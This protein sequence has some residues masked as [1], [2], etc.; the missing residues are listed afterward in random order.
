[1][2]CQVCSKPNH[3]AQDC[4]YRFDPDYVPDETRQAGS[5]ITSYGIDTNWYLDSGATDHITGELDK[6]T[7]RERY[8]SHDKVH[9]ANRAGMVISHIGSTTIH[10][11]KHKLHLKNILHVPEAK[12]SLAS[13]HKIAIDNKAFVEIHLE[14]FVV[15]DR[16]RLFFTVDVMVVSIPSSHP[17]PRQ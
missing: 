3:S 2:I 9:T 5:A 8:N 12:K 6:S 11:Q 4:W 1:M 15:K 10:S 16:G 17:P 13:A 14:F 7:T